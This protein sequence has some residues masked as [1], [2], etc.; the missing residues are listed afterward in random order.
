LNFLHRVC[1][2]FGQ[3]F[4]SRFTENQI[5]DNFVTVYQLIDEMMDNGIPF[6]TE[7]NA[8]MEMIPPHNKVQQL[9]GN[10]TGNS[11]MS[12]VLPDGSLSNTPWR[13]SGVKYSTNEIY[14]DIVEEV[15]TTIDPNGMPVSCEVSGEVQV[16]CK[17]L[18]NARY[19]TIF[20]KS[21]YFR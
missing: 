3:Y 5:R 16:N 15:D 14:F 13:K 9:I 18:W 8:L 6:T 11:K 4:D 12:G 19:D 17:T 20:Y 10:I 1:E 2:I 21:W 7:P